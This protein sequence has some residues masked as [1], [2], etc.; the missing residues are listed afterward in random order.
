MSQCQETLKFYFN[1]LYPTYAEYATFCN[2]IELFDNTD[3]I[4]VTF[5]K[6]CYNA[7]FRAFYNVPANYIDINAFLYELSNILLD[8]FAQYQKQ[9]QLIDAIYE[10]EIDDFAKTRDTLVSKATNNNQNNLDPTQWVS[11][12]GEQ[13]YQSEMLSKFQ[14]YTQAISQMPSYNIEKFINN[15]RYLFNF[16]FTGLKCGKCV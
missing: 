15:F 2:E 14:G 16:I 13:D 9:K 5:N 10:L 6:W 7:L 8:R 3:P 11:Y 1:T 12:I 4:L